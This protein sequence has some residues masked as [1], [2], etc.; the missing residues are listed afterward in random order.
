MNEIKLTRNDILF[1]YWA[2]QFPK[3]TELDLELAKQRGL[4]RLY[5]PLLFETDDVLL[6]GS[7]G[8]LLKFMGE[9]GYE[10]NHD[11]MTYL[12]RDKEEK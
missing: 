8:N 1:N 2:Y 9:I 7:W 4:L 6:M 10:I 12:G 11:Y 3:L 5:T